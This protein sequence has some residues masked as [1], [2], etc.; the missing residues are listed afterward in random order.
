LNRSKSSR[1]AFEQQAG[2]RQFE[3]GDVEAR[4]ILL[5]GQ[6]LDIG[7]RSD[8]DFDQAL[9]FK[10]NDRFAHCRPADIMLG[11]KFPFGRKP[12]A[13]GIGT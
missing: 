9:D 7:T 2:F 3:R 10:R 5:A 8:A 11:G 1:L 4:D 12:V 13:H 6:T